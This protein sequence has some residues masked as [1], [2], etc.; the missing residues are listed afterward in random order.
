MG[1][2]TQWAEGHITYCI[3]L[4]W[5]DPSEKKDTGDMKN[6]WKSCKRPLSDMCI[7]PGLSTCQQPE[8]PLV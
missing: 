6:R 7:L 4:S 2:S 1:I 8:G 3:L 5:D